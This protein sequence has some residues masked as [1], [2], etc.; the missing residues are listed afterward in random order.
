VIL[1]ACAPVEDDGPETPSA[2]G[3]VAQEELGAEIPP[4]DASAELRWVRANACPDQSP[5]SLTASDGTGLKL[6]SLKARAAVEGPIALTELTL[7]FDNPEDRQ[8]EGRFAITLPPGAA[9]SRFAMKIDGRWQE[10]EVVERQA[11]RRAYEDFLH[12]RQDPALLENDAGNVFRARVFPIPARAKKELVISYSQNLPAEGEPWRLPLCGLP[13]L[14]E[15]DVDVAIV[16]GAAFSKSSIAAKSTAVQHLTIREQDF[17]PTKDLEAWAGRQRAQGV[18]HGDLAIARIKPQLGTP[19][20]VPKQMTILFDTS[21]SRALDFEGQVARLGRLIARMGSEWPGVEVRVAAF[22]QGLE[23]IYR[24][25]ATDF[26]AGDEARI[27]DRG[28]LGASD[29][30]RA[31]TEVR[32]HGL[33]SPRILLISDGV[34]TAGPTES[35]ELGKTIDALE[36]EGLQRIDALVDGGIQDEALLGQLTTGAAP[37]D[38][39][40]LDA[41]MEMSTIVERLGKATRSGI[42]VRVAGA[43]WVWPKQL[44]GVQPGDEVLVFAQLPPEAAFEVQLEG[45][46]L[47]DPTPSLSVVPGPLLARAHAGARITSMSEA[48]ASIDPKAKGADQRRADLQA[49][50]VDLSTKHRVLSDFTAL[51]VL[52]TE[53]DYRRFDIDRKALTDILTVGPSGVG[54]IPRVVPR[55][56]DRLD[57]LDGEVV[58]EELPLEEMRKLDDT[59]AWDNKDKAEGK[60]KKAKGSSSRGADGRFGGPPSDPGVPGGSGGNAI[61]LGDAGSPLDDMD[62]GGDFEEAEDIVAAVPMAEPEPDAPP[63]PARVRGGHGGRR[64]AE[65]RSRIARRPSPSSVPVPVPEKP[66]KANAWEGQYDEVQ[67][68]LAKGETAGARKLAA[69]WR[70]DKPGDVLALV[71]LGDALDADGDRVGAARAY[72]SLIDLFPSRA[73]LR[74]MAGERLERLGDDG[75]ALAIDTYDKAV[76]SRPDHPT[77]ARMLAYALL[78]QGKHRQAFETLEAAFDRKYPSGRFAEI[79]RILREDLGLVGKAWIAHEP[80][81]DKEV[82]RILT[83]RGASLPTGASTRFVL[84]WET[85]ANDVDLHVYDAKGHHAFY[86]NKA[87]PSGGNL[88]ADVTTGFGPECFTIDGTPKAGPYHLQAHYYRRGPM[89]YGM[90]TLQVIEHDG[91]G[92]LTFAEH[93]FVI[94]RDDAYVDLATV[95]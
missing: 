25:P 42:G 56:R 37:T 5:M 82:R 78:K 15:L 12:R 20:A 84:S 69:K 17:S 7:A 22:D 80:S 92:G 64:M 4:E 70:T 79:H 40:V 16:R 2:D 26:D 8:L 30:E 49:S 53:E 31:L 54:V 27:V 75:L 90:G 81:A 6:S 14:A 35:A 28:A 94:M 87:L 9:I 32:E 52:E 65:E 61:Q 23:E 34:V 91:K 33:V 48:L 85:D 63:P 60:K 73:D 58:D 19:P 36:A 43:E 38:G 50:I 21:A 66:H 39:I 89:G 76:Q 95:K 1:A 72:G 47:A 45:A 57:D 24:G 3:A 55:D 59:S 29:L 71:A 68:K 83:E 11:A 18:R 67:Q 86:R 51:L 93:P 10:G 74:R 41:R 13:R 46:E 44:D 62:E 77:G 88:Y